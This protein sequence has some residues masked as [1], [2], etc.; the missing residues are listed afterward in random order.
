MISTQFIAK[1]GTR[2]L[3]REPMGSDARAAMIFIN[4]FVGEERSGIVIT[5]KKTLK[6]ERKWLGGMRDGIKKKVTV[7]L[8]AVKDGAVVGSCEVSRRPGKMGHIALFGIAVTKPFRGIG[9]GGELARRVIELAARRMKGLEII[10]LGVID[11]NRRAQS[12]YRKLGFKR[13]ATIPKALKEGKEYHS[14]TIMHL[15]L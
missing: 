9:L 5:K 4:S 13:V 8:F 12:L 10:E 2:F 11:Y 7:H 3:L 15:Y 1:D 14:H 6:D